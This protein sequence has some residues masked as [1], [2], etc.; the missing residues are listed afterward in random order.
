MGAMA[1]GVETLFPKL[2]LLAKES[3]NLTQFF[4]F[5][6]IFVF[7]TP[8]FLDNY[9]FLFSSPLCCFFFNLLNIYIIFL[10]IKILLWS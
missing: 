9:I 2:L 7:K 1:S 8:S 4:L 3:E 10:H 5:V 6:W